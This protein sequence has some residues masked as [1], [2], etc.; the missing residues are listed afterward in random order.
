MSIRP[1][2][3]TL[4]SEYAAAPHRRVPIVSGYDQPSRGIK[5]QF[6]REAESLAASHGAT[7]VWVDQVNRSSIWYLKNPS[8]GIRSVTFY[9]APKACWA[10][11]ES[12]DRKAGEQVGIPLFH[13]R[14]EYEGSLETVWTGES[15]VKL[16]DA[17]RQTCTP[18]R[19]IA[20]QLGAIPVHDHVRSNSH[21]NALSR[22]ANV[23]AFD[24][25]GGVLLEADGVLVPVAGP[26]LELTIRRAV[27][28][29]ERF[30]VE[31]DVAFIHTM[32]K[33]VTGIAK[34]P[35]RSTQ[36]RAVTASG[37]H[38]AGAAAT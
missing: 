13:H 22:L 1:A 24:S 11:E 3:L 8:R 30:R 33:A 29:L 34:T 9:V 27:A 17:L 19:A 31:G 21:V 2:S 7:R 5:S 28:T 25:M 37:N 18:I 26:N 12:V 35:R 15:V 23:V 10:I 4:S 6:V 14:G 36:G 16:A 20:E 38:L 32:L